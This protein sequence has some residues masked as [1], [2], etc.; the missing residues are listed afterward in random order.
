MQWSVKVTVKTIAARS[1]FFSTDNT[2][3]QSMVYHIWSLKFLLLSNAPLPADEVT[4]T[5]EGALISWTGS[6]CVF[7]LADTEMLMVVVG[8]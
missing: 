1:A 5:R 2:V 6:C 3:K 4:E 8:W 7:G